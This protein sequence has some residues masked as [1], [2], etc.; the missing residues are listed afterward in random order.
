MQQSLLFLTYEYDGNGKVNSSAGFIGNVNPFRWKSFYFDTETGLYYAN[1]SYYDPETGTYLDASPVYTIEKLSTHNLDRNGLM[2]NNV[3]E[4]SCNPYTINTVIELYP[5]P[6]YEIGERKIQ[7]WHWVIGG[8]FAL[9]S[10]ILAAVTCGL[11][12][13]ITATLI[14]AGVGAAYGAFT[15]HTAGQDV[16]KGALVGMLSGIIMGNTAAI[17]TS[18]ISSTVVAGPLLQLNGN[19]M[20][21]LALSAVG[22]SAAGIYSEIGNQLNYYGQIVDFTGI[23]IS[24]L[25]YGTTNALSM[26]IGL[27]IAKSKELMMI[28]VGTWLFDTIIGIIGAAIDVLRSGLR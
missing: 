20:A 21:G 6:A 4:L 3:L 11:T 13:A 17:G 14:G 22:G 28:L 26:L 5:D 27:P 7:W 25:E 15:A 18:I 23:V 2:C 8:A 24:A 16:A 10:F 12:I 1:G 9:G 19:V